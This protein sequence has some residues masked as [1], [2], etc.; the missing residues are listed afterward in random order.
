MKKYFYTDGTR[1]FGPFSIEELKEKSISR[2][3]MVWFQELDEWKNAGSIQEL[4]DLFYLVP[5]PI[6]Q[7]NNNQI[8]VYPSNSSGVIDILVFL[9]IAYWLATNLA[10]FIIQEFVDDWWNYE[11]ITFF[12]IGSNII[13]AIV[14]IVFALS[15][16]GKALKI[17]TLILAT[18]LSLYILYTNI[19]WMIRELQ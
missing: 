4:N 12:Q 7:S 9:S 16:K 5:P 18:L 10:N 15:V 8:S 17:T 6:R 19:E 14:P 11:F 2:E 1:N 13:F 3:T